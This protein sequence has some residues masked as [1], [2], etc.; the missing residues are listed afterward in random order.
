MTHPKKESRFG[1]VVNGFLDL[2]IDETSL[3]AQFYNTQLKPLDD[4]P[5]VLTH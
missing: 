4:H 5:L 3:K 1:V 2:T